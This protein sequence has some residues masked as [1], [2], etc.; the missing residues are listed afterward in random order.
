[1]TKQEYEE[2]ASKLARYESMRKDASEIEDV[3]EKIQTFG[4]QGFV[5]NAKECKIENC[6]SG[7]TQSWINTSIH[8][9]LKNEKE[10]LEKYMEEI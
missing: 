9:L 1:M 3:I 10:Q 4:I 7:S 5:I 6:I 8:D 2:Q